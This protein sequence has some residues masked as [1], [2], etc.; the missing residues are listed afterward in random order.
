M[1]PNTLPCGCGRCGCLCPEHSPTRIETLCARHGLPV[2]TR[3][4]F[5]EAATLVALILFCATVS[6]WAAIGG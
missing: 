5:G 1:N 2:V 4:L 3:W 6:L